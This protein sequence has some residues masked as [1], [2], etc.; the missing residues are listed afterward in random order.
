MTHRLNMEGWNARR[1]DP[2]RRLPLN[3]VRP[4]VVP[5]RLDQATGAELVESASEASTDTPEQVSPSNQG[6]VLDVTNAS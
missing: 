6:E 4:L 5:S 1:R 2:W 3:F